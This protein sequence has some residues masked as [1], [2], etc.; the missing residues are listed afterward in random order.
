MFWANVENARWS[1][2]V[3]E[4][5]APC[6]GSGGVIQ[7]WIWEVK[8]GM[9]K[10]PTQDVHAKS[11]QSCP[12]LCNPTGCSPPGSSV[13]GTL[14]ARILKCVAISFSR[15]SLG[16]NPCLQHLLHSRKILSC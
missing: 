14:Q 4:Q 3:R 15:G 2:L 5:E 9:T 12:T 1:G 6:A 7:V 8:C 16:S 10:V 11:L 13:H